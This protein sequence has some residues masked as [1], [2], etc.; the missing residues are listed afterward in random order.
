MP[1]EQAEALVMS[2]QA[3]E[4]K[5]GSWTPKRESQSPG[6]EP[7]TP[8]RALHSVEYEFGRHVMNPKTPMLLLSTELTRL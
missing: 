8:A 7:Q 1:E 4:S 5:P 2:P 3:R 6:H